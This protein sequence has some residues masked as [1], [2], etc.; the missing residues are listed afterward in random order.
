MTK[1]DSCNSFFKSGQNETPKMHTKI[2]LIAQQ[3]F[4]SYYVIL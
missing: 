2:T 4:P 1:S 3:E